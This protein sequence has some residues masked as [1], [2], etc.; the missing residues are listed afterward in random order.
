MF[1]ACGY[2]TPQLSCAPS[3]NRTGTPLRRT[4]ATSLARASR[5]DVAVLG[6]VQQPQV[7]DEAI[8]AYR[9]APHAIP[10]RARQRAAQRGKAAGKDAHLL[11]A[12]IDDLARI[13]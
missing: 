3:S 5:A 8:V 1:D 10:H 6:V 13:H 7:A 11:F 12:A 2:L 9:E 4:G